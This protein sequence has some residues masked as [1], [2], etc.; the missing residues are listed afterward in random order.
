MQ[1]LSA[2]RI[3]T[4]KTDVVC[5]IHNV[6]LIQGGRSKPFCP[7]CMAKK[8]QADKEG[9][10]RRSFEIQARK[11]INTSVYANPS[12]ASNRFENFKSVP[13]SK[14]AQMGN[15]M[16][17]LASLYIKTNPTPRYMKKIEP[18]KSEKPELYHL[19]KPINAVVYGTPGEGKT[20]LAMS[21]LH[22]VNENSKPQQRCL[23][24]D[25]NS[26]F[27]QIFRRMSDKED[28]FQDSILK[29]IK[30]ADLVV[31]DDLG[32]ESNMNASG[33]GSNFVQSFLEE[34]FDNQNRIIVTTNLTASELSKTYNAKLISRLNKS[35]YKFDFSGIE[36]K[37]GLIA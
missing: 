26:M 13:G 10:G 14:E 35:A 20:H 1:G 36:D 30:E 33:Q 24:V 9:L 37:R 29:R 2:I 31:L 32:T 25:V 3:P 8:M 11:F 34:I 21:V 28:H 4:Q 19:A 15:S 12:T 17:K 18:Y 27:K 23:F 16:Y 22:M 5:P 6:Q 7:K